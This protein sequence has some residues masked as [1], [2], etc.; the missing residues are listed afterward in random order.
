MLL[1]TKTGN[2]ALNLGTALLF[3]D[4]SDNLTKHP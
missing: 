2:A 1:H 3:T 4:L